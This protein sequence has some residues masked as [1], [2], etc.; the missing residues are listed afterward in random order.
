MK[1]IKY[2]AD[3]EWRYT[4]DAIVKYSPQYY[5]IKG[6][7]TKCEWTERDDVGL[8]FDNHLFTIEEYLLMEQ[9]YVN[10]V[11]K[12]MEL[13]KL[14]L[15]KVVQNNYLG[16]YEDIRKLYDLIELPIYIYNN[17]VDSGNVYLIFDS[18]YEE[19]YTPNIKHMFFANLLTI[20]SLG[21]KY[22]F[23]STEESNLGE[24]DSNLPEKFWDVGVWL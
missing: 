14:I 6:I 11:L 3:Q 10:A 17:E 21:I 20:K 19:A 18:R 15:V 13:L 9:K 12:I 24:W 23:R 16:T 5:N 7:Y 22:L 4:A 2:Y 8:I 1:N